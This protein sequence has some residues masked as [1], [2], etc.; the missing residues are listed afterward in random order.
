MLARLWRYVRIGHGVTEGTSGTKKP[1]KRQSSSLIDTDPANNPGGQHHPANPYTSGKAKAK[2][3]P[4]YG[5]GQTIVPPTVDN[6]GYADRRAAGPVPVGRGNSMVQS[7][8]A[9]E[10]GVNGTES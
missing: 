7:L 5:R 3:P 10:G 2:A 9:N 8:M 1:A 4:V 6:D